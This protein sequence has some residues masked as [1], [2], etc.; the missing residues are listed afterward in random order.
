MLCVLALVA[1][2]GYEE[3][4]SIINAAKDYMGEISVGEMS[5]TKDSAE[6]AKMLRSVKHSAACEMPTDILT[7]ALLLA[8]N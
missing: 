5:F 3:Y 7:A 4:K 6:A 1:S 8:E 2:G